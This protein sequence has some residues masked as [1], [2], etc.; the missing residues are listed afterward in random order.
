MK[1][2]LDRRTMEK[3]AKRK[4]ELMEWNSIQ[5][6]LGDEEGERLDHWH[7][8]NLTGRTNELTHA[9]IILGVYEEVMDLVV[10]MENNEYWT[11][12]E[13]DEAH[14]QAIDYWE[15]QLSDEWDDY[16]AD[17]GR[18]DFEDYCEAEGCK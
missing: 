17:G 14:E 10:K 9:L 8:G 5:K 13:I 6:K 3:L 16:I 2:K 4:S 1:T 7:E 18:L 11:Q 15:E 12:D